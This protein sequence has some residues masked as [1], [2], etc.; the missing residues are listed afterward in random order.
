M[1]LLLFFTAFFTA[2]V[3]ALVWLFIFQK[4]DRHPEPKRMLV[5]AFS[6]GVFVSAI[7]FIIQY[8]I[9][10]II[11]LGISDI[12]IFVVVLMGILKFV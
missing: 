11:A 3:P 2:C 9:S 6:A 8:V 4:E 7:V 12:I 5:F 10:V 1:T